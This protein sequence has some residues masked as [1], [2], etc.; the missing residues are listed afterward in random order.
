MDTIKGSKRE[1]VRRHL[2]RLEKQNYIRRRRTPYGYVIE[3]LNSCKFEI[4]K[5]PKGKPQNDVSPIT[6]KLIH[7]PKKPISGSE[8]PKNSINKE[9]AAGTQHK[10]AASMPAAPGAGNPWKVIGSDIAMGSPE[11]QKVFEYYHR[12]SNCNA[13]SEVM[14]RTIQA[15]NVRDVKVPPPFFHAKREVERRE[16]KELSAPA[17]IEIP[18]L[19]AEPWVK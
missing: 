8:K 4:W 16:K 14:E 7:D 13:L 17:G 19:E 2:D 1:T 10:D 9:D 11:F 6:G 5:T 15:A 12:T 3:V 18:V